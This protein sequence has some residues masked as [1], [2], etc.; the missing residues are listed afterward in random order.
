M[1]S[2]PH[3]VCQPPSWCK[4]SLLS[5]CAPPNLPLC[6]PVALQCGFV[7]PAIS[8]LKFDSFQ[9]F[10]VPRTSAFP[11]FCQQPYELEPF[12]DFDDSP[13][14]SFADAVAEAFG[15]ETALAG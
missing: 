14:R 15:G 10:F 13:V 4:R 3:S 9:P 7:A 6:F 5:E 11:C 8:D 1:P 2:Q 12:V